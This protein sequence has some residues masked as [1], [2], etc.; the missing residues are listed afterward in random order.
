[1]FLKKKIDIFL[2]VPFILFPNSQIF[3]VFIFCVNT[4]FLQ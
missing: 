4:I 2:S 3:I 1:M